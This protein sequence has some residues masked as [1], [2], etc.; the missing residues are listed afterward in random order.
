VAEETHLEMCSYGQMSE[1]QKPRD[2]DLDLGSNQGHI[3]MQNASSITNVTNH[4]T[5][6]SRSAEIWPFEFREISTFREV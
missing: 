5:V 6:A 2:L 1:V 4:V 3:S